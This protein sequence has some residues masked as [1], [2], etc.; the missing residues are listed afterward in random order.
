[1][2]TTK[3]ILVAAVVA[4]AVLAATMVPVYAAPEGGSQNQEPFFDKAQRLERVREALKSR[5]QLKQ[6]SGVALAQEPIDVDDL[7]EGDAEGMIEDV[8]DAELVDETP[9]PIWLVHAKGR[10]WPVADTEESAEADPMIMRLALSKV[11]ATN[12]GTV[13]EVLKGFVVHNGTRVA[14]EGKAV[15][16]SD[17]VFALRLQ[18]EDLEIKAV[19]RIVRARMGVRLAMRGRM[20]DQGEEYGFKLTGKAIPIK[21]MWAWKRAAP[22]GE[23]AK[24][25]PSAYGGRAFGSAP[26]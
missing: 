20:V 2:R 19:G 7:D 13:Y 22:A 6:N 16:R 12:R 17:G 4:A 9:G 11:R 23:D 5:L 24:P 14:V 25:T 21:P 8:E 15:L 3:R 1:M 10:A 26:L 18:G